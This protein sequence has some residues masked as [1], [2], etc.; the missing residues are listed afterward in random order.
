MQIKL[1][2]ILVTCFA[3]SITSFGQKQQ[4]TDIHTICGKGTYHAPE[5]VNLEQAKQIALDR[6]RMDAIQKEFGVIVS[7]QNSTVITNENGQ[8]S[9]IFISVG[10]SEGKAEWIG[11][12]QEPEYD[13]I[14]YIRDND[15]EYTTI[16]SVSVCG[17]A[18]E[19]TKAVINFSTKL[20]RNGTEAKFED[21][22]FK[23]RDDFYLMFR[24]PVDGF[25]AVYLSDMEKVYCL[26]PYMN[27]G[28]GKR[29][30]TGGK[31]YVFFSE[32]HA[33]PSEITT[34]TE[35][36]LTC[37]KQTERN[38]IYIIFSP[39]EF[40]KANDYRAENETV[41]PRELSFND[42]QKWL[43]QNRIRDRD[44]EVRMIPVTV[45]K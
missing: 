2:F 20:L 14:K 5:N 19:I 29:K 6:A 22:N 17:E 45:T 35:Y 8:S 36:I 9:I 4:Q 40:T 39:N 32:K 44:M 15:G 16:V 38:D 25:L 37:K 13:D 23:H 12:T 26:L 33:E 43:H 18:R 42:F 41:L 30:I 28:S 21:D 7:Q 10:G 34:V 24:S 27:E 11:D 1:I 3:F 31:D